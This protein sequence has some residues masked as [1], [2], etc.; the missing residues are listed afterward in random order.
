MTSSITEEDDKC[1]PENIKSPSWVWV[2]QTICYIKGFHVKCNDSSKVQDDWHTASI[3]THTKPHIKSILH[4]NQLNTKLKSS[5]IKY[6]CVT[7]PIITAKLYIITYLW[8]INDAASNW[9]FSN[10]W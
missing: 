4:I 7:L 2:I 3:N 10:G 5:M 8:F 9:P 6:T 1:Y